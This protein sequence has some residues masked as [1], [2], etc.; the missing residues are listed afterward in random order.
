MFDL[1]WFWIW[2]FIAIQFLELFIYIL[3]YIPLLV[4]LWKIIQH[5]DPNERANKRWSSP[6]WIFPVCLLHFM[7]RFVCVRDLLLI[8]W[9]EIWR[10]PFKLE[11]RAMLHPC[12]QGVTC[13][14]NCLRRCHVSLDFLV[15][16][17]FYS[18]TFD[19]YLGDKMSWFYRQVSYIIVRW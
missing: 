4:Y 11:S 10:V 3:I 14:R 19:L 1:N 12:Q 15:L 13:F 16:S 17:D 18:R 8:P 5:T 6:K 7:R 2:C 9:Y